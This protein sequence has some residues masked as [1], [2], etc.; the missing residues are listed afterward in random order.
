[1]NW[2][3]QNVF[4]V[5]AL[6]DPLFDTGAFGV[7]LLLDIDDEG[8]IR[9]HVVVGVNMVNPGDVG[10]LKFGFGNATNETNA[11]NFPLNI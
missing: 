5:E 11:L 6:L 10:N 4:L 3:E 2:E 7:V 9:V 1:M 8:H